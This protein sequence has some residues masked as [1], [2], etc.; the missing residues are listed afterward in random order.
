VYR[1]V[2]KRTQQVV[3]VKV[4]PLMSEYDEW[5]KKL[6]SEIYILH[7]ASHP[8]ITHLFVAPTQPPAAIAFSPR[9]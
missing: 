3:A 1:A 9:N 6:A 8:N 2:E 5:S 7:N 4:M